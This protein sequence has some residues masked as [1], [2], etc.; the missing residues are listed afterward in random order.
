MH[1]SVPLRLTQH[2][3]STIL[4]KLK[5][6]KINLRGKKD[7][8]KKHLSKNRNKDFETDY[9]YKFCRKFTVPMRIILNNCEF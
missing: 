2:C 7:N 3:K 1:F 5:K 6:K 4:H 8:L 9:L